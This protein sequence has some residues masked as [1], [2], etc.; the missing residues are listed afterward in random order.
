MRLPRISMRQ[1]HYF[2]AAAKTGQ[3]SKA[4]ANTHVTQTAVT[5]SIKEL[6]EVLGT[7]LFERLPATG[8]RLTQAGQKFLH[9]AQSI[10]DATEDALRTPLTDTVVGEITLA[11]S[12]TALTYYAMPALARFYRAF[13]EV[14][15]NIVEHD[16]RELES[17]VADGRADFGFVWQ[18]ALQKKR[19]IE[20]ASL[21]TCERQVWLS[22]DHPL[23]ARPRITMADIAREPY[24]MPTSDQAESAHL[25]FW[26]KSRLTPKVAMRTTSIEALR[27]LVALGYG[28]TI[29]SEML[30]R[31]WSLEGWRIE[32]RP[33]HKGAPPIEISLAWAKKRKTTPAMDAFREFMIS[34]YRGERLSRRVF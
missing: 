29:L 22:V 26:K 13:P 21:I 9:R 30:Y 19:S 1:L 16:R 7:A 31:P 11:A 33:I 2:L 25:A 12:H 27:A 15:V 24:L 6:E 10:I 32:A 28:V 8:V 17:V 23:L 4:A 3:F 14:R 18:E 5:S 34:T 20:T